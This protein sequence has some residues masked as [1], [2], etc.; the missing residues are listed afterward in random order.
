ML[1]LRP[2]PLLAGE[3]RSRSKSMK[4]LKTPETGEAEG[5]CAQPGG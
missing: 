3:Q 2:L 4:S 5:R 1:M